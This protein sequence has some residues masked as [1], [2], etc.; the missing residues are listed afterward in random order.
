MQNTFEA[1][2]GDFGTV[3]HETLPFPRLQDVVRTG[4]D[5]IIDPVYRSLGGVLTSAELNLRHW[6]LEFDGIAVELDEH[7][8]FNRYRAITLAAGAYVKLPGFPLVAYRRYCAEFESDCLRAG[9]YGGKWS[10]P[11]C[12][13][14]FG[15]GAA[16][17]VLDGNGAPRWKQRAFYDFVKDLSPLVLGVKVVRVAIWDCVVENGTPCTVKDVLSRPTVAGADAIAKLIHARAVS[18]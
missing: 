14:Q 9:G 17:K 8:H 15:I 10:K 6:D 1:L 13:R 11:S 3:D 18:N 5:E 7:L 2:L 4:Y 16:P 12:E